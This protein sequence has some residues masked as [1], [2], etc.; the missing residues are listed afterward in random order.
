MGKIPPANMDGL[1]QLAVAI[2]EG[3]VTQRGLEP[4]E[5]AVSSLLADFLPALLFSL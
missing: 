3:D 2:H 4:N 5:R 1:A